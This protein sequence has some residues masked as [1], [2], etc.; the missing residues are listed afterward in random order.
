[1]T[2][3]IRT[4][5]DPFFTAAYASSLQNKQDWPEGVWAAMKLSKSFDLLEDHDSW[6]REA[7]K[8]DVL[9][10]RSR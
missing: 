6:L 8:R 1:M 10:E 2:L 7:V 3:V 9:A 5:R 4:H